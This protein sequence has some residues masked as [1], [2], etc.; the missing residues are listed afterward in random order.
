MS[1]TLILITDGISRYLLSASVAGALLTLLVWL[2]IKVARIQ[3]PVYRH[4][5]WLC[6]LVCAVALP[7]IGLHGPRL[8]V[9]VLAPE[10]QAAKATT[11]EVHHGRDAGLT[12]HATAQIN[13]QASV[14][15]ETATVSDANPSR[16]FPIREVLAGLWLV[17]II[18]MLTRLLVGWLRIRRI[19]LSADPVSV[20]GHFENICNGRSK[21]LLTS[22]VDGPV[23]LGILQPVILLPRE[24]YDNAPAQ[25][26][27]MVLSHEL[28]HVERWDCWTNLFQRVIEAI[29]FFHPLLWYASFQ[30]TQQREQICDNYVIEKGAPVM[31]YTTLLSR[32][33]EQGLEKTRFQA[34]ALFEG[35]LVQRVRFLLD[36]KSNTRTKASHRAV[37]AC[38]IAVLTCLAL[39]TVR[40][41]AK[42][43]ANAS[44]DPK[45]TELGEAVGK[46]LTTYSDEKTLTLKDGQ[47]GRMKV[48]KNITPVAEILIT[49][50]FAANRTKFDLECVDATGKA[51]P[52]TKTTSPAIHDAQSTRMGLGTPFSVNGKEIM[53]KIQLT[54]TRQ[55]GNSVAVEVKVLFARTPTPEEIDAMLLTRGKDGQL[56]L[57]YRDISRRITQHKLR[58]GH[59]PKTIK[60]LN[61]PLPKDV[62]SPTGEDYRYE[63][64]RSRFILSSCGEDGIYGNDDDQIVIAYQGGMRSGQRHE[65]YPLEEEKEVKAQTETAYGERPRGDCSISGKV[66]SAE[67]GEPVDHAKVYLFYLGTHGAM[68]VDVA[69]DGTFVFKDIPTGPF[70]LRTTNTAGYQDA[71]Y[72]PESKSGS[73]PQFSLEDGEHRSGIVLKVKQAH[74]ISGKVLDEDGKIPENIGTLHVLAWSERDDGKGYQNEQARVNRADGS[75]LIDGLSGK[76]IYIMAIDWRAAKE[77]NAHPPIYYPG[78]FSRNDA[79][80]ITFDQKQDNDNIN[81]A[82]QREGGLILKG[83]VI[84]ETGKPVPEA[85]V[86]VHRRDMLFD[87]V[88]AYTDQQGSYQIQGLA[89]GEF[90]VHVDAVHR[91]FVRTRVPIDL[92]SVKATTQRD[93]KLKQGVA[94]SDKFVDKEGN[95]WQIGQSYGHANIKEP[96]EPDS[97]ADATVSRASSFS[98]TDFRNKYRPEDT[99]RGSGG[100]FSR[101]E[102]DYCGGQM[103]FP[104]KSTFVIQGMMPGHT[105]ISF[106]PKKEGCEVL[107]ILHDGQNIMEAGIETKPGQEITD[108][109]IVIGTR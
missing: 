20:D 39:V 76:P 66:V 15:A 94:I 87:F 80:L 34:V 103:L 79:K 71:I 81:I 46:R 41:E 74:R 65:L 96:P 11:P 95:E 38:A 55:G 6:A 36:P 106:S 10:D 63:A 17:G 25:D 78:T 29:F 58:T 5:L 26:L 2:I 33:A 89:D 22:Q 69:G 21:V 56:Q 82:L 84:D 19:C 27:R 104:T 61:Q 49:P 86:V 70:L 64:Q 99:T 7:A 68:F 16:P 18:F 50:H 47:T 24:M 93:F 30:L 9:E 8:T 48:K 23:C 57:N 92:D 44:V 28:A 72:N 40:L 97:D 54:P 42:S 62:Y 45:V 109:T 105:M 91:G 4:M 13:S 53:S 12:R 88:T 67:T 90:L 108:V 3:A 60:E 31:D 73:Y 77:G 51:I 102:G 1:H 59:Y 35:R 14:P 52:G 100:S 43:Q 101:G 98:L 32:I 83:T 37:A 85:F 75:Y 107:K